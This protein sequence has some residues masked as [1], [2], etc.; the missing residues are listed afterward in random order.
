[1]KFF[2]LQKPET[3]HHLTH[4]EER[5]RQ[6]ASAQYEGVIYMTPQDFLE[7]VTEESP[8]RKYAVSSKYEVL[9]KYQ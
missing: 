2:I 9:P 7:S 5:F 4:R 3:L 8:R 6:F 1:M